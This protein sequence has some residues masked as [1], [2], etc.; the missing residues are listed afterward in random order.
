MNGS[1]TN[2]AKDGL[3]TGFRISIGGIMLL[4]LLVALHV[5]FGKWDSRTIV[6]VAPFSLSIAS[7]EILR[8][9]FR[10]SLVRSMVVGILL[11]GLCFSLTVAAIHISPTALSLL[12]GPD[13]EFSLSMANL[14]G[15]RVRNETIATFVLYVFDGTIVML[16]Y[17]GVILFKEANAKQIDRRRYIDAPDLSKEPDET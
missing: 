1:R 11:G 3:D 7:I 13:W 9:L 4:T 12:L 6:T 10:V 8:R 17:G 5:A 16:G 2:P 14:L 15:R